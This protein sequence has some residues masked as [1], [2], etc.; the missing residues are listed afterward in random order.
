MDHLNTVDLVSNLVVTNLTSK[1]NVLGAVDLAVW[2]SAHFKVSHRRSVLEESCHENLETRSHDGSI[3][4][5]LDL[6]IHI[7]EIVRQMIRILV[8]V[9][10]GVLLSSRKNELSKNLKNHLFY[11]NDPSS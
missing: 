9:H 6:S 1:A 3:L 2:E 8:G 4:G 7:D 11:I 5:N 10:T